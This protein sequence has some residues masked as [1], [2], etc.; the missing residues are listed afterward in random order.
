M[1]KIKEYYNDVFERLI[2]VIYRTGETYKE[3]LDDLTPDE[4][5][6]RAGR[7]AEAMDHLSSSFERLLA[8]YGRALNTIDD[9][10]A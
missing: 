9:D 10:D 2:D 3:G 4:K 5:L 6:I 1:M 7:Y 8:I